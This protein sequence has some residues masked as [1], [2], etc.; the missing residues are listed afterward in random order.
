MGKPQSSGNVL[1]GT[2]GNDILVVSDRLDQ[3]WTVDGGAGD[4]TIRGGGGADTLLGGAGNDTILGLP[5]DIRLDGGLGY[6]TLDLSLA[7]ASVRYLGSF[8]GQLTYWPDDTPSTYAVAAGFERVVG[9]PYKDYFLGGAANETFEGAGGD[10]RID[11]G[12][13]N[14]V[15]IG[16]DGADYFEFTYQGGGSDRVED[17][18]VGQDHLFFYSVPQPTEN[19]PILIL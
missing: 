13:G 17:F 19:S 2:R 9:S 3:A 15:L 16:G 5:N 8:G 14:D 7:T 1:K 12:L 10:D 4:D 18:Q 6:D 11:G